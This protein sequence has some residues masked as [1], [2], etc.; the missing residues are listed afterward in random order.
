MRRLALAAG[1]ATLAATLAPIPP[2]AAQAP[3]IGAVQEVMVYAYGTPAQ[4]ARRALFTACSPSAP[5]RQ[6]DVFG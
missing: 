4:A 6:I 1:L 3:A 2:A 5:L